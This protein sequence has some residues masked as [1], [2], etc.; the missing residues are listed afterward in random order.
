MIFLG[1]YIVGL[2][3]GIIAV[4]IKKQRNT[5]DIA[6]TVL[7]YQLTVTVCLSSLQGFIGHVFM[8][9]QIASQI[10]WVSNGFQKELGF[11]SLGIAIAS[12]MCIWFRER[13]W[14]A[15]II[16]FST[17]YLGAA[18]IHIKDKLLIG[19]FN[20]GSVY[21]AIADVLIPLTLIVCWLLKQ[22]RK[23]A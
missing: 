12:F 16:I 5:S 14:L 2:L 22:K 6:G 23:N 21:P 13:F 11:A 9:E 7:L 15:V 19:N 17:F 3:V 1:F 10:G 4:I 8:S 20:P 18:A